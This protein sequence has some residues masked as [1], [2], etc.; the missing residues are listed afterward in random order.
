VPQHGSEPHGEPS[1]RHDGHVPPPHEPAAQLESQGQHGPPGWPQLHTPPKHQ[2]PELQ[3]PAS[4]QRWAA[5]PQG[6]QPKPSHTVPP[7]QPPPVVHPP[8]PSQLAV[9]QAGAGQL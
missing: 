4:Q 9:M 2:S 5:P 6:T 8:E 7:P 1:G 3:P